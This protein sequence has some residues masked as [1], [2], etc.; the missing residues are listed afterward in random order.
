MVINPQFM[1]N[2]LNGLGWDLSK[3]NILKIKYDLNIYL[4]FLI[5]KL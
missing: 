1:L 2:I 3:T 5:L 4:F